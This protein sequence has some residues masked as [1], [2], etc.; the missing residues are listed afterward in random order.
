MRKF[1][2]TSLLLVLAATLTA[3][4]PAAVEKPVI[5]KFT[6]DKATLPFGGGDV[7]FTYDVTG[8]D[9]LSIDQ[10]VGTLTPVTTGTKTVTVTATTTYI[11]TAKNSGGETKSTAKTITVSPQLATAPTITKFNV[12]TATIAEAKTITLPAGG[13]PVTFVSAVT[14]GAGSALASL[15]IDNGVG[16]V[17]PLTGGNT[18]FTTATG[19][20]YTLTATSAAGTTDTDTVTINITPSIAPTI[21]SS[22]PAS[23]ATGVAI[24]NN[25]I[26]VTFDKAMNQTTTQAA[27]TSAGLTAPVFVWSNGDKTLT[28]T[29]A[30]LPNAPAATGVNK[31]VTYNFAATATDSTGT[32]LAAASTAARTYSTLKAV[33]AILDPVATADPATTLSGSI[34]FTNGV[35]PAPAG[36]PATC[37]AA[38]LPI[39][40]Q[41]DIDPSEYRIGDSS[42][43]VGG[44]KVANPNNAYKAFVG[45]NLAPLAAVTPANLISAKFSMNQNGTP[46]SI[47]TPYALGTSPMKLQSISSAA[48]ATGF[49]GNTSFFFYTAPTN[50]SVDFSSVGAGLKTATVTTELTAD[51]T[52]RGPRGNRALFRLMFP[53]VPAV[54]GTFDGASDGDGLEDIA[55]FKN[56]PLSDTPK[57]E[58]VYT[59]P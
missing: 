2:A 31:T 37:G 5:N 29:S 28:V 14:A 20:T 25:T 15:T 55:D 7:I 41:N 52:N 22:V 35:D 51:L 16:A 17:T 47:G 39:C 58:I 40:A 57:L 23:G 49:L 9:S 48:L 43:I 10:S 19:G 42:G 36:Q 32:P 45:F 50:S 3:C 21:V 18:P 34:I 12:K 11:L 4:P 24:D 1:L 26:A 56:T 8:A 59:Q 54:A 13:G 33:L 53:K 46:P 38:G 6:V 44:T 30:S 27:F